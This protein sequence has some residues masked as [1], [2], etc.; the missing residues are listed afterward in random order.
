MIESG[1]CFL[2]TTSLYYLRMMCG[3]ISNTFIYNNNLYIYI[4][5]YN[6]YIFW[7]LSIQYILDIIAF[8]FEHEYVDNVYERIC[9]IAQPTCRP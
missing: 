6:R 1:T 7:I 8:F 5:I 3:V 4:Y 2:Y 9:I